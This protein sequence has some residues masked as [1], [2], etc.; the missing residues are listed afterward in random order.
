MNTALV[1]IATGAAYREYAKHMTESARRFFPQAQIL[2]FT[3]APLDDAFSAAHATFFTEPKGYPN[4]TLRRYHTFL[5]EEKILQRYDYLF[6]CD[7]DMEFVAP[8]G[9]IY[10]QDFRGL[11]ATLHPGY[12]G[13]RGTPETRPESTAY[14]TTNTVYYCGGFQGGHADDYLLAMRRMAADIDTDTSKGI[15]AV[16]HDESHWN[17]YLADHA[18]SKVLT[19]SYCY[20]EGYGGRWGWQPGDYNPIL[21]ALDKKR[22]GNHWSQ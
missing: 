1:T 2:A 14:C 6:Y 11:V 8:V 20:P 21:M 16:W 15:T 22:R 7:A 4:E 18:P 13:R 9:D 12:V 19:P 17:R 3:D 10:P 5:T